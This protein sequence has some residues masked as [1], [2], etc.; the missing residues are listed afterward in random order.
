MNIGSKGKTCQEFVE[1]MRKRGYKYDSDTGHFIT[2]TGVTAGK[3]CKNGYRTL[4][5][6]EN[7][8]QYTFCEHRCVWAW[9]HG[10]IP[11]GLEVNHIDANRG[12]NK[13]EN[14]ELVTHSENMQHM[15][16]MGH[17]NFQR[18]EKSGKA[19]YSDKEVQAMRYL[20]KQ[21]WTVK[22]IASLFGNK[23]ENVIGRLINGRRYGHITED[24]NALDVFQIVV[25]KA[26]ERGVVI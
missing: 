25:K 1:L 10:D 5:L 2:K 13:I 7:G 4:A 12:N 8:T 9:F 23:N 17:S 3:Q 19:I 15:I 24:A 20:R 26:T 16:R 22:Q 11:N 18:G 6:Q 14:L 21:N